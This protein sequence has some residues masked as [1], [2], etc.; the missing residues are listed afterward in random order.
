MRIFSKRCL[1][2]DIVSHCYNL[3]FYHQGIQMNRPGRLG[4]EFPDNLFNTWLDY[5]ESLGQSRA[6]VIREVNT[7]LDR[8]YDN[9]RFYRWKKQKMTVAEPVVIHFIYP[10][11]HKVLQWFFTNQGFPV[12]GIDFG[13]L[14]AAIRPA[15]KAIDTDS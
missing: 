1:F 14:A 3:T 12:K 6:D 4:A 5:R 8:K 7:R 11:L 2:L 13:V 15:V 10:E 9:D